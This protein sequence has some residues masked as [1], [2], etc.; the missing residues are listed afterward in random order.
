MLTKGQVEHLISCAKMGGGM[1]Y[2]ENSELAVLMVLMCY[3]PMKMVDAMKITPRNLAEG[4]YLSVRRGKVRF[5]IPKEQA[6]YIGLYAYIKKVK[7]DEPLLKNSK[8][9][10]EKAFRKIAAEEGISARLIEVYYL[11]E[12]ENR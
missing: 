8:R 2:R 4:S 1:S 11:G 12:I 7:D 9:A 5:T 10:L 3:A 6:S